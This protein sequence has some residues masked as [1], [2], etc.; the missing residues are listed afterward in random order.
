MVVGGLSSRVVVPV[1]WAE[2]RVC[3]SLVSGFRVV[4]FLGK[5]VWL[6]GI[7]AKAKVLPVLAACVLS[8]GSGLWWGI[9]WAYGLVRCGSQV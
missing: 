5:P 3:F 4:F 2:L 1:F 8:S 9:S 6:V 7:P